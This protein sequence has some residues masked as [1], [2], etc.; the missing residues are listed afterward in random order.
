M[1][2][3]LLLA[4]LAMMGLPGFAHTA[5]PDPARI[6]RLVRQLG[7]DKLSEGQAAG[8]ALLEMGERALPALRKASGGDDLELRLRAAGLSEAIVA[9]LRDRA[10][11]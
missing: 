2:R 6:E 4:A 5:G 3:H 10:V 1:S 11:N 9:R 7:S 8:E